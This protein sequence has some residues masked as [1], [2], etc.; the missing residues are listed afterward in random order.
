MAT[1]K[2]KTSTHDTDII[3]I[4][5][6]VTRKKRFRIEGDNDRILELNTSDM[7]IMSRLT[8]SIAKLDELAAKAVDYGVELDEVADDDEELLA[9]MAQKI[10]EIDKEMRNLLDYV[11]DSNVSEICAPT[12]TM[13]DPFN[14]KLRYEHIIDTLSVL[15]ENNLSSELKQM[16]TNVAKHTEKYV[17]K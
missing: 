5:L 10:S 6:S 8:E 7:N 9:S 3:D 2:T 14:G 15:Y 17:K 12:G 11:F 4:D 13:Y 1:A 16:R